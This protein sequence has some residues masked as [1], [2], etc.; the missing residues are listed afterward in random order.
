MHGLTE[1]TDALAV[2]DAHMEDA[3][4]AA[5]VQIRW[6]QVLHVRRPERVEVQ[7][8]VDRQLHGLRRQAVIRRCSAFQHV[9][10]PIQFIFRATLVSL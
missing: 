2:D 7:H 8:A 10:S 3:A 1:C 4:F 9:Q 6:D 5:L